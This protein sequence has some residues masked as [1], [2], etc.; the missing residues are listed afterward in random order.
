VSPTH[1]RSD[2]FT[3]G[4]STGLE[5]AELVKGRVIDRSTDV[6]GDNMLRGDLFFA[7]KTAVEEVKAG[8]NVYTYAALV[9]ISEDTV[10]MPDS[11]VQSRGGLRA[12]VVA[13]PLIITDIKL[14]HLTKGEM[15]QRLE[16]YMSVASIQHYLVVDRERGLILHHE[17]RGNAIVTHMV[18][19]GAIVFD[20]FEI[21]AAKLLGHPQ[22][23]AS[24][25]NQ[26]AFA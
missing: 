25:N 26:G 18:R 22:T 2:R 11:I 23:E 21:Q 15:Q 24:A 9:R 13:E 7:F 10:R 3:E 16:D 8:L 5:R 17:R 4:L 6:L 1:T 19:K 20:G 12:R 14:A